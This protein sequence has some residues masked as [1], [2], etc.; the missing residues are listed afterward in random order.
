MY[1]GLRA[2]VQGWRLGFEALLAAIVLAGCMTVAPVEEE[3]IPDQVA[4]T[5]E[6]EP[7]PEPAP[8][9]IIDPLAPNVPQPRMKPPIPRSVIA[10]LAANK[11]NDG[12]KPNASGDSSEE[13][14][15]ESV[16]PGELVGSDFTSVLEV[17]RDPDAVQESALT[18]VWTYS[19]TDCTVL[20]YF[21]PDIQ[22]TTFHLLK[23]DIRSAAGERL[24][25]SKVCMKHLVR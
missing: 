3:P 25:D 19:E 2:S 18:V 14:E 21:Y 23:Y 17:L 7:P 12:A 20:L 5:P 10:R 22:T 13:T 24:D 9:E 11:A 15:A 16:A 1:S 8:P 4:I 6:I